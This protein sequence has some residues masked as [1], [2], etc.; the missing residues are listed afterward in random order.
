[1]WGGAKVYISKEIICVLRDLKRNASLTDYKFYCF[2]GEPHYL[3]ISTGLENHETAK[4]SFLNMNWEVAPFGRKDYE[5]FKRLPKK[6]NRFNEMIE[7]SRILSKGIPFLRVDLY[8]VNNEIFF[9]E[10]TF[11]PCSGMMPFSPENYDL[12]LGGLL[13]LPQ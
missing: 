10:L 5:E 2:N 11:S 7:I 3:Y 9:S 4:I 13:Q 6:P 1:M 12:I 8:E